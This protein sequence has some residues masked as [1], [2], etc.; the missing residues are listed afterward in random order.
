[1]GQ[2]DIIKFLRDKRATSGDYFTTFEIAKGLKNGS[3]H[4]SAVRKAL[5]QLSRMGI[6]ETKTSGDAFEWI[7][8]FR[9]NKKYLEE[10]V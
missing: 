1:M 7:K 8:T 10:K 3:S 4:Y 9:L 5:Y 6:V 2:Q